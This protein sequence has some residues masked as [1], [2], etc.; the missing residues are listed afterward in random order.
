VKVDPFPTELAR[1]FLPQI[2]TIP[3]VLTAGCATDAVGPVLLSEPEL[4]YDPDGRAPLAALVEFT[5]DEPAFVTL[6]IDDGEVMRAV[7]FDEA[8]TQHSIHVLGLRPS[9]NHSISLELVD[10]GG[11]QA[12]RG[13]TIEI[14]TPP[15]P[16]DFPPI[17][18]LR[19]QPSQ[20]EPGVTLFNASAIPGNYGY[21]VV[22][23][24]V[25]QVLWYAR[26]EIRTVDVRRARSGN[27][28]YLG[29]GEPGEDVAAEMDLLG[30]VVRQWYPAGL[31]QSGPAG[32][33][34]VDTDSFHHEIYELPSGNF[35]TLS[36]EMRG[37]DSYP[38][39]EDDPGAPTETARV[40]GD[41]V[42]EFRRN[43]DLVNEWSLLDILAPYRIG[44][45]SLGEGWNRVYGDPEGGTRDWSHG[46]AVIYEERTDSL[47][48]SLRS[49]D[50]LVKISRQT[51]DLEWIL[52]TSDG[53]RQNFD[54][55]L[56]NAENDFEW[57]YH[58]HAPMLTPSGNI[59]L[60]DNGNS[61]A[62][63]FQGRTEAADSYSRAVEYAIDEESMR[64]SEVWAYGGPGGEIFYS[65][66][67]GDADWLGTTGNV[68]VTD[69]ARITDANGRAS[70]NFLGGQVWARIVEVTH[71]SPAEKVFELLIRDES[72]EAGGWYVTRSERLASLYP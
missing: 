45:D 51:G 2:L 15:L 33:I 16:D 29:T 55:Y 12:I 23:D 53:W 18:L 6:H 52:G 24:G 54:S 43:G 48:V 59:L 13:P 67:L 62:R 17:Q 28:L 66:A 4:I 50:A 1:S 7:P 21:L 11:N 30:N 69:G 46:N 72:N 14:D 38:T 70:D 60:F 27:F 63:P 10:A 39:S 40:V 37:L 64:V 20:M 9:R 42:V 58:Q 61:R 32:A 47:I 65:S 22:V 71:T 56:L 3:L 41:V 57:P 25:G 35:L 36:S 49:Q 19:A 26:T 44:Y 5:T 31:G 34:P 68:L 8:N